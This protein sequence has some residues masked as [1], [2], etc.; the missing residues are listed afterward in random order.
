MIWEFQR[1]FNFLKKMIHLPKIKFLMKNLIFYFIISITI[2]SNIFAQRSLEPTTDDIELAKKIRVKYP[3][4]D[5]VNLIS[6][7]KISFDLNKKEGKVIVNTVLNEK[8]MNINNRATI[9]KYEFYNGESSIDKMNVKN[10]GDRDFYTP[11]T[12]EFYKDNDLFYNDA[13]IKYLNL[14]FPIQG[15]SFNYEVEKKYNDVKY[16]TSVYFNDSYPNIAKEI[17]MKKWCDENVG[18]RK[19][20]RE[21]GKKGEEERK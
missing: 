4:D 21:G 17:E 16:F 11:I 3:K 2:S 14:T 7:D 20:K 8:M 9:S 6:T 12:D 5:V 19:K 1:N 13:K 15:Y 18:R 10:R